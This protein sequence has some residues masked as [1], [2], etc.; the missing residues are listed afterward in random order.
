MSARNVRS[1][2]LECVG[3]VALCSR[4]EIACWSHARRKYWEAALA[5]QRV[6]CEALVRIGKI[7]EVDATLRAKGPGGRPPPSKLGKLRR[8]H[9]KPLVE[10]FL[11][12]AER[13]YEK[14][15]HQRGS[16]RSALGY[17]VRQADALRAFLRDGRLRLDNNPSESQLR[18]V[19]RIRD[20]SLF[21]GS[22]EHAAAAGSI[23][24]MIASAR[25]HDLDPEQY[26]RDMIRVLPH[27]PQDRNLE[28]VPKFW[29]RTRSRLDPVE[30]SREFG[31]LT[32]PPYDPATT[33]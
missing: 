18:K 26:L 8:E 20:A 12:F 33:Q 21:A 3:A 16:L 27:W 17:S 19:V 7:F 29:P 10:E 6:A 14:V 31:A 9:L 25:L 15:K 23:L 28:L 5:K 1:G 13:E 2:L 4:D 22:T 24:S 32:V 11:D 30:L